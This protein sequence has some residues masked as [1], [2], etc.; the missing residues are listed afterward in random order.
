MTEM[1][2]GMSQE[3]ETDL[4]QELSRIDQSLAIMERH[5]AALN[6]AEMT[7]QD[8]MRRWDREFKNQHLHSINRSRK[9]KR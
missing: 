7:V 8:E 6:T 9:H 1:Y 2:D 3:G 4:R 5:S